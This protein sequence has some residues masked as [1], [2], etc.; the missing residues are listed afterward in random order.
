MSVK[1]RTAAQAAAGGVSLKG[2]AFGWAL[3]LSAASGCGDAEPANDATSAPNVGSAV[4]AASGAGEACGNTKDDDLDGLVDCVDPDCAADAA[5]GPAME[6]RTFFW[7]IQSAT[8]AIRQIVTTPASNAFTSST[9]ATVGIGTNAAGYNPRD[10]YYYAIGTGGTTQRH[11]LKIDSTGAYTDLGAVAVLV[12]DGVSPIAGDCDDRGNLYVKDNAGNAVYKISLSSPYTTTKYSLTSGFAGAD[13]VYDRDLQRFYGVDD[14]TLYAWDAGAAAP[15]SKSITGATV[16]SATHAAVWTDGD[17]FVYSLESQATGDLR[18]IDPSTGVASKQGTWSGTTPTD[19]AGCS[20]VLP[21]FEICGNGK[22]DDGDGNS[23]E[24]V[25]ITLRDTDGDGV[26]NVVDLDDD[27]DGIPDVL[28][29]GDNDGDGVTDRLD[30]DSDNDGI[31]DIVEAGH[32]GAD[33]NGN[34][35]LDGAP[36]AFG[37]NG[38]LDSLETAPDAAVL[39]YTIRDTDGDGIRDAAE[40]DSDGDGLSDLKEA[41][42]AAATYDAN[43]DSKADGTDTDA[44][45]IRSTVDG[46]PAVYGDAGATTLPDSDS[47]G[48]PDYRDVDSD[49]DGVCDGA[50]ANAAASCVA[51]PDSNPTSNTVCSDTDGDSCNDCSAG[52]YNPSNDGPDSDGDGMCNA[53]DACVNDPA[54]S[55]V[56][57]C[58]CGVPDTDTDG[59]TVADCKDNCVNVKNVTQVNVDGDAYGAACDCNDVN[60]AV[61]PGATETC[62]GLDDNCNGSTDE[63]VKST[64]Y[65]DA[66]SD[67]FGSSTTTQACSAPAGYVASNTDCDDTRSSVHPGATEVCN[68]LDDNCV[69]GIDEGVKSTFYADA[70]SD[71]YGAASAATLACTAPAGYVVNKTDCDDVRASVH[72]G[73]TEVCNGLDDNCNG[74]T[75]EGV[76]STFYADTDSDGLGDAASTLQACSAPA[77]YTTSHGPDN[78]PAVANPQQENLDGDTLGDACDPDDD[79]DGTPDGSDNCPRLANDQTNT[80]GDAQG[81]AC[82]PDD[83]NDGICDTA[84]AV[85]NVCTSGPDSA[86]TNSHQCADADHDSCDDCA[87][88]KANTKNDGVDSD[89][90][91]ICDKGEDTD[92]DGVTDG[93]DLDDDN[94]GV[95]DKLENTLGVSPDGDADNDG[96]PNYLDADDQGNGTASDCVDANSDKRCDKPAKAFDFD[97]DGVP[98]HLDLD[99]DDDGIADSVRSR[100]D[101]PGRQWRRHGGRSSGGQRFGRCGRDRRGQRGLCLPAARHGWRR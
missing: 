16:D 85:A 47:D 12:T 75:D 38:L 58:G 11:L 34:G 25:C 55:A 23:D 53:G 4:L 29:P 9:V 69:G 50:S 90:D 92:Q 60:A 70:D 44:D 2:A 14:D 84:T 57:A 65:R 20:Y 66:D 78:C 31:D 46:A 94:D 62:N 22:D 72:P 1:K 37:T 15:T 17:G 30:L 10:G 13:I 7:Q 59:D 56:G 88:G 54:K 79:N 26:F 96:V 64:F 80:D 77:G 28:E 40:L 6:C 93:Q 27:N 39:A 63:G 8:S 51:G 99:S 61:N 21:P 36:A 35:M 86:P 81:D 67:G 33:A 87:L 68:G 49:G 100:P 97:R 48:K 32:A 43:N 89:A 71:G 5:C 83:D 82:D 3:L 45:G 98:N 101:Q 95:P 91:G 74:S 76:K 24:A 73:A 19:G 52:H 42:Y 18:R 41:G